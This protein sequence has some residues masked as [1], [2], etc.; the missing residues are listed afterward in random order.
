[1]SFLNR[2]K[3]RGIPPNASF[4]LTEG[5]REKLQEFQGDAKSRVLSALETGG[6]SDI[7]EIAAKSGLSRGKVESMI[8]SLTRGGYIQYIS[9]QGSSMGGEL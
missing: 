2:N 3:G 9:S 4:R 8:P 5:G 1:M 6:T 7:S